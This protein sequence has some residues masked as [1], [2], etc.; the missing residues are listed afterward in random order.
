[1]T[2]TPELFAAAAKIIIA[3]VLL[4]IITALL[5]RRALP[6]LVSRRDRAG[7]AVVCGAIA[8]M[9]V[10]IAGFLAFAAGDHMQVADVP[11]I[12]TRAEFIDRRD[13]G[14]TPG[15]VLLQAAISE[16]NPASADGV[17]ATVWRLPDRYLLDLPG[18][19]PVIAEG[20]TSEGQMWEWPRDASGA[21]VLRRGTPVVVWGSLQKGMG[22]GGPTS[23]TGLSAVRMIAAGDITSF[24]TGYVPV[25]ERTGRVVLGLA[26]LNLLLAV[27]M[28]AVGVATLRRLTRDGT[29]DPP[30]ITWRSGPRRR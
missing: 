11:Q 13:A 28:A 30:R 26:T 4:S 19:P 2:V 23:A 7:V 6:R 12:R 17:V 27:A 8:V 25:V 5:A 1:M 20:I 29:D 18:G 24:L 22:A 10:A 21:P 3:T 9:Y 15:G 14:P 16:W